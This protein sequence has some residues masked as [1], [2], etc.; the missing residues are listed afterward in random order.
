MYRLDYEGMLRHAC[1]S[2]FILIFDHNIDDNNL[3]DELFCK[4]LKT[5]VDWTKQTFYISD[6][7]SGVHVLVVVQQ[8]VGNHC[9]T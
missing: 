7:Q 4:W 3:L 5:S 8:K 1:D 2:I 6:S 9:S